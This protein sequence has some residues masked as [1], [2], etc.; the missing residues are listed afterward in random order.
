[1]GIGQA[2]GGVAQ[3]AGSVAAANTQASAARYAA[4]VQA[5]SA[6]KALAATQAET[7]QARSDL[8]PFTNGA[9]TSGDI[10][11]YNNFY[12][13]NAASMNAMT[14]T[15]ERSTPGGMSEAELVN[16]PGY[17]FNLSQGLQSLA[18]SNAAKGLG[19]SGAAL[20]AAAT[21]ATGLADNT[22]QTQ[23]GIKQ[24]QF[25]DNVTAANLHNALLGQQFSMLASPVQTSQD[26]AARTATMGMQGTTN[27]N[28]VMMA[29]ANAAA[30]GIVGSANASANGFTGAGNA[31]ASGINNQMLMQAIKDNNSGGGGSG[32][33]S[34]DNGTWTD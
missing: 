31:I 32:G 6:D 27:A 2:I 15:A 25:N 22:Y 4:D 24:Q 7:A 30:S 23:F 14:A 13:N 29:G 33:G 3:A 10:D 28:N 11:A 34:V 16:T 20:K 1:M 19:V 21:Y 9:Q 26:S 12:K 8:A 18:S 17:Q 5:K